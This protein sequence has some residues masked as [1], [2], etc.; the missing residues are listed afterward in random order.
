MRWS[1]SSAH[2]GLAHE[3]E[4]GE[5]DG[6]EGEDGSK[7]RKGDGIKVPDSAD[8][9]SVHRNPGSHEK[10]VEEDKR[11]VSGK[12]GNGI[13]DALGVGAALQE[14]LLVFGD[15]IDVFLDVVLRHGGRLD[16]MC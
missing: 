13:G 1:R 16:S 8:G 4:A 15:E 5:E 6:F 2:S 7:Q 14:L 12:G 11:E 3:D 9:Q 10:D